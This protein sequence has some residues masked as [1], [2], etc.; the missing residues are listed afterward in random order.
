MIR[1]QSELSPIPSFRRQHKKKGRR[2]LSLFCILVGYLQFTHT[3]TQIKSNNILSQ[4]DTGNEWL[5]NPSNHALFHWNC[6]NLRRCCMNWWIY[7]ALDFKIKKRTIRKINHNYFIYSKHH[8][9]KTNRIRCH[10]FDKYLFTMC[11]VCI[12]VTKIECIICL[13]VRFTWYWNTSIVSSN[14]IIIYYVNSFEAV[15]F[16]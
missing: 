16:Y 6:Q 3:H 13:V 12:N 15:I 9:F 5:K 8:Q 11:L 2:V 1:I 14:N 4:C 7:R 10:S